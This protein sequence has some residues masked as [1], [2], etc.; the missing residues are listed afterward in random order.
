MVIN[1]NFYMEHGPDKCIDS[2][3]WNRVDFLRACCL[4]NMHVFQCYWCRDWP[5]D[6]VKGKCM[7]APTRYYFYGGHLPAKFQ[8]DVQELVQRLAEVYAKAW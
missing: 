2:F 7:Y 4:R 6:H 1:Q 8:T 5:Y 3:G